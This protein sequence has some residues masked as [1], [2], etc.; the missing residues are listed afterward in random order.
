[1]IALIP[2]ILGVTALAAAVVI[3]VRKT[4]APGHSSPV[5][6]AGDPLFF[7]RYRPGITE[8]EPPVQAH[9]GRKNDPPAEIH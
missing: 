7:V 9:R 3:M 4:R 8:V 2:A 6:A 1:M 5:L